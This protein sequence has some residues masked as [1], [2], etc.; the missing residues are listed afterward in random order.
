MRVTSE[1]ASYTA[2]GDAAMSRDTSSFSVMVSKSTTSNA[3]RSARALPGTKDAQVAAQ[4]PVAHR[5]ADA[6]GDGIEQR[7]ADGGFE[8]AIQRRG[9]QEIGE[10]L[11]VE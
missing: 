9:A 1:M 8:T 7:L 4:R 3:A 2:S 5:R 10:A 6:L 11:P